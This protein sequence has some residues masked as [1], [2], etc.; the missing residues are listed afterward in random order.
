MTRAVP[1]HSVMRENRA[2]PTGVFMADHPEEA[3]RLLW[4]VERAIALW[5]DPVKKWTKDERDRSWA[6]WETEARAVLDRIR[7]IENQRESEQS[8]DEG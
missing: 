8:G 4:S 1:A 3:V 5:S 7:Q 6:A 2:M